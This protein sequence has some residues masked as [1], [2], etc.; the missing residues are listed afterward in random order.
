M[1]TDPLRRG[2][3][4]PR[5]NPLPEP[6]SIEEVFRVMD[7]VAAA[8]TLPLPE[9]HMPPPPVVLDVPL[10]CDTPAIWMASYLTGY[11]GSMAIYRCERC[12]TEWEARV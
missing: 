2:R 8:I 6:R 1:S 5:K 4:R 7:D 3:G 9:P 12:K 11:G 10:C